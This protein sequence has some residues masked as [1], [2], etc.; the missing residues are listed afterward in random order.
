MAA[1][2][3]VRANL[4]NFQRKFASQASG[5]VLDGRDRGQTDYEL[6]SERHGLFVEGVMQATETVW[7]VRQADGRWYV[8]LDGR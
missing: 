8:D 2:P 5:A 6:L 1:L 4:L 3:E 7:W